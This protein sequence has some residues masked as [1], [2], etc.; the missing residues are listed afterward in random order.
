MTDLIGITPAWDAVV[1]LKQ[2]E[3]NLATRAFIWVHVYL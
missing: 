1:H 2:K 3:G